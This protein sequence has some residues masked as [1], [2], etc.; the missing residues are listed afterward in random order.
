MASCPMAMKSEVEGY[1]AMMFALTWKT[2]LS[3]IMESRICRTY[4]RTKRE[5]AKHC[6]DFVGKTCGADGRSNDDVH[7]FLRVGLKL[8][9]DGKQLSVPKISDWRRIENKKWSSHSGHK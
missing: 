7:A 8:I 1:I 4:A 5:I 9:E 2:C 6:N 3:E